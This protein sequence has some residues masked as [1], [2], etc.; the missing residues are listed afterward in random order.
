MR[1]VNS[2]LELL[3]SLDGLLNRHGSV[4]AVHVEEVEVINAKTSKALLH[5]LPTVL[6]RR[7]DVASE[8]LYGKLR[9]EKDVLAALRVKLEPLQR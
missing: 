8:T 7:V 2:L 6:R 5:S 9:G 3:H 4:G 1:Q